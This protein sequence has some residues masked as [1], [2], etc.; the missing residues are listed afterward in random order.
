[1]ASFN[2]D[3]DKATLGVRWSEY[4]ESFEIYMVAIN[5]DNDERKKCMLLHL[6]GQPLQRLAKNLDINPRAAVNAVQADPNAVPPVAAVAA[7]P[8][9]NVYTA[10]KRAL[11][12]HFRPQANKELSRIQF[13]Q[14]SQAVNETLDQ[15]FGRL[16]CL[17]TG[18]EFPDA[19]GMIKSQIIC[20]TRLKKL[21]TAALENHRFTLEQLLAKGRAYEGA[22]LQLSHIEGKVEE[23]SVTV[24]R[25]AK[26]QKWYR[27]QN[28]SSNQKESYQ[29]GRHQHRNNQSVDRQMPRQR[30]QQ[31]QSEDEEKEGSDEECVSCGFLFHHGDRCPATNA[32][33][34][35]CNVTG[36][37]AR[38]CVSPAVDFHQVGS[39]VHRNQERRVQFEI[40]VHRS[41]NLVSSCDQN[42]DEREVGE[43]DESY[44]AVYSSDGLYPVVELELFGKKCEFL[45]DTGSNSTIISHQVYQ[46]INRPLLC[47]TS[48]RIFPF[49][50]STPLELKGAFSA[51]LKVPVSNRW[52]VE[53]VFVTSG[54]SS[55]PCILSRRAAEQLGLIGFSREVE[56]RTLSVKTLQRQSSSTVSLNADVTSAVPV[57][58][59]EESYWSL[60][61][62]FES[63]E[64]KEHIV[65]SVVSTVPLSRV[66][67]S[68]PSQ[69]ITS[70]AAGNQVDSKSSLYRGCPAGVV[71]F[72]I[73]SLSQRGAANRPEQA[74]AL[75]SYVNRQAVPDRHRR[76]SS[77]REEKG[78]PPFQFRVGPGFRGRPPD[79][80][81]PKHRQL[82][83]DAAAR[84]HLSGQG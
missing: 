70:A 14:A 42:E 55:Q 45:L 84:Q 72:S 65:E 52:S 36:H 10:L 6:A 49:K 41:V 74:A 9:E 50:Q 1:V 38:C 82:K 63:S 71:K 31:C 75:Q 8:A 39:G 5:I 15:Y 59:T 18:C 78:S 19:D 66:S 77:V 2:V 27:N 46:S 81:H 13:S 4:I 57:V 28:Q 23:P 67:S 64:S 20:G 30:N 44:Y 54:N 37:F 29:Q 53:A 12:D 73:S 26:G 76:S 61:Q 22:E 34:Y 62:F 7:I 33:C 25:L 24:N 43:C 60:D 48:K 3:G 35:K 17:V 32:L 83:P 56:M 80:V 11:N 79:S 68:Q 21:R 69:R 47:S 51:Q 58:E 16:K 40:P